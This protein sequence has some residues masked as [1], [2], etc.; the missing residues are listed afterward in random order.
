M[1][2][3]RPAFTKDGTITA[4]NASK[5]DDGAAAVVLAS[6]KAVKEQ[7]L[8]PLARVVGWAGAAQAPE[9]FT[10]APAI[11]IDRV[12]AK[13]RMTAADIDLFEINEAFAVVTMH[14]MMAC[15][16]DHAKVNVHGGAV[17]LGHPIGCSGTRIVA[18]LVHALRDR[19]LKRGLATLCI[20]GGEALALV[21]ETV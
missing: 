5:I 11:A 10:T 20:G 1:A 19:K 7:G 12:L 2:K 15:K 16:L 4:A 3:L 6:E 9:W 18:T 13:L 14:A 17:S 8:A 21:V